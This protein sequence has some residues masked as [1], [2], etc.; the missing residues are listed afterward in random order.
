MIKFQAI[1][2]VNHILSFYFYLFF[3]VFLIFFMGAILNTFI[4]K[5][6]YWH[7]SFPSIVDEKRDTNQSHIYPT[8]TLLK[9]FINCF[10]HYK[11][12]A[13]TLPDSTVAPAWRLPI[14]SS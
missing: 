7:N 12:E 2:L 10:Y 14:K 5:G 13:Q 1:P 3:L 11:K 9:Y 4:L 6:H 8:T